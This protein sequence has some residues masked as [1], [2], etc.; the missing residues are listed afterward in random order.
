MPKCKS[1]GKGVDWF[2]VVKNLL[3]L[4]ASKVPN[5]HLS[6]T[7]CAECTASW[8]TYFEGF[9]EYQAS[10]ERLSRAAK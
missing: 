2:R 1:C 8:N 5:S 10:R 9:Q 6:E 3:V 7:L 4:K